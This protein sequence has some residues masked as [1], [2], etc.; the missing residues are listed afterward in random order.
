MPRFEYKVVP[1]PTKGRKGKG[2]R[3][4]EARFAYA[5]QE[6]MNAMAG[7]G[8]EYQ[9]AETL[10]SLERAGLASSTTEWRNVLIFRRPREG[11]AAEFQPELLPAPSEMTDAEALQ[12]PAEED[13]VVGGTPVPDNGVEDTQS[14][15]GIGSSLSILAH[16]RS[17]ARGKDTDPPVK[18]SDD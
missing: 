15:S 8:W 16:A 3:G 12:M 10:P 13:A 7:Y 4:A 2:V 9:R 18:K 17:L 14:T 6:L 5:V 1:A 11:D